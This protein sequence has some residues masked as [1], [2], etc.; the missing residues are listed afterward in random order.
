M[1]EAHPAVQTID[2]RFL[3]LDQAI[4]VFLVRGPDGCVLVECGPMSTRP[5]L[6][7]ALA[8]LG[9]TPDS[10][11]DVLLTHVHLDHA[12]SSGWWAE[13][14]ARVHVHAAGAPHLVD[15]ARLMA[16]A[17]K[18]YG[19]DL[20]RLWGAM[21]PVDPGRLRSHAASEPFMAGGLVWE[22][23]DTPGHA[24]H[25][26]CYRLGDVVFTGDVG[27]IRLPGHQ[28]AIAPTPP[29]D[30]DL[31]LWAGSLERLRA[32]VPRRLYLT[33]FGAVDDPLPHLEQVEASLRAAAAQ[34]AAGRAA[35]LDRDGM[36][37]SFAAWQ[38]SMLVRAGLA[39]GVVEA[40]MA[41]N[42]PAMAVDGLLRCLARAE[43]GRAAPA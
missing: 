28:P 1:T 18:V 21:P 8:E 2:L 41:G 3:G 37:A 14:G 11:S 23:I 19:A 25:H 5:H 17:G 35:G 12:G 15:P 43:V 29:P 9:V 16:S 32:A 40:Y 10:V 31:A 7:A 26:L 6:A 4:A 36:V 30:I 42:P 38:R 33:H 27:G 22:A 39:A 34:V 13:R 20:E 24:R